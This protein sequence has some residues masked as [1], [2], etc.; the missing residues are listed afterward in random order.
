MSEKLKL[1]A[2]DEDDLAIISAHL[3]DAVMLVGDMRYNRAEKSMMFVLGRFNWRDAQIQKGEKP[4]TR[5]QSALQFDRVEAVKSCNI[6]QDAKAA[7]LSLLSIGFETTDAPSG[8]ITLVFSGGG[9]VR[10]EVECIEG[11]LADLGPLWE[12][13]SRPWHEETTTQAEGDG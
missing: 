5:H 11:R 1:A 4:Y 8:Y 13:T 9:A 2:T 12:T 3:Q 6:R 10:L 7:V